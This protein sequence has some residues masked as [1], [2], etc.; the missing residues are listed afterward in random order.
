MMYGIDYY[1]EHDPESRWPID[2][3][4]IAEAGFTVVRLAEFA[5][6]RRLPLR[7]KVGVKLFAERRR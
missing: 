4:L 5:W 1:P 3:R 2:A 7:V 6:A